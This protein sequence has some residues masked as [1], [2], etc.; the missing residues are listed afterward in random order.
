MT[1]KSSQIL[2]GALDCGLVTIECQ[3]P[4]VRIHRARAGSSVPQLGL[5]LGSLEYSLLLYASN[6]KVRT[7]GDNTKAVASQAHIR[8]AGRGAVRV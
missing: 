4:E 5:V 7:V 1:T 3:V 6:C 8:G 2:W